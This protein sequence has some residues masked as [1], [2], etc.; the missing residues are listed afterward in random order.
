MPRWP[1]TVKTASPMPKV[2]KSDTARLAELEADIARLQ[3]R[4]EKQKAVIRAKEAR[5]KQ[6]RAF[7]L[8]ECLLAQETLPEGLAREIGRMLDGF[9]KRPADRAVL[10]DWIATPPGNLPDAPDGLTPR[11]AFALGASTLARPGTGD[12]ITAPVIHQAAT[13]S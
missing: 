7:L 8:G 1:H 13:I 12:V 4:A 3:A 5:T 9:L 11:E 6:R 10:A 2:Q